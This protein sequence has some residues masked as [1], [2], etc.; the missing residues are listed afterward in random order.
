MG[1]SEKKQ[2]ETKEETGKAANTYSFHQNPG[3]PQLTALGKLKFNVDPGLHAQF[4]NLR[5]QVDKA[6]HDPMGAA[7]NPYSAQQQRKAARERLG[8]QE[9]QAYREGEYDVNRLNLARDTTVAGLTA[10]VFAQDTQDTSSYGKGTTVQSESP[11]GKIAAI[12]AQ[13]AMAAPSM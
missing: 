8:Q 12:G 5:N 10:P 4:G 3:S 1:M 6:A 7:Y 13:T 9:A 11:W 2:T